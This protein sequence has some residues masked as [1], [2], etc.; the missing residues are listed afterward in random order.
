MTSITNH[1]SNFESRL[2]MPMQANLKNPHQSGTVAFS[3]ESSRHLIYLA[4][5]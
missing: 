1:R 4:N 5:L 3:S 2:V